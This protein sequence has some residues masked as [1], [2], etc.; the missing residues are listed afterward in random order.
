VGKD[1]GRGA[2]HHGVEWLNFSDWTDVWA[3][4][5]P[6][7][8]ANLKREISEKRWVELSQWDAG[9]IPKKKYQ[10]PKSQLPDGMVTGSTKRLASRFYQLKTGHCLI[11][12]FFF[13]TNAGASCGCTRRTPAMY[14]PSGPICLT[15][16]VCQGRCLPDAVCQN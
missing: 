16:T 11:R 12:I 7:S 14:Y 6:Q 3:I 10:I 15:Y 1:R 9:Q 4:P 8:L 5:L 2:G 13:L